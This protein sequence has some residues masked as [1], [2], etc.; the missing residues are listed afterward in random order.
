MGRN[1]SWPP[2]RATALLPF[3]RAGALLVYVTLALTGVLLHP[4]T[5]AI[6]AAAV[7]AVGGA[8]AALLRR[9]PDGL[10]PVPHPVAVAVLVAGLPGAAAAAEHL[11]PIGGVLLTAL[12]LGGTFLTWHWLLATPEPR[13]AGPASGPGTDADLHRRLLASLPDDVLLAEWRSL[14]GHG[15]TGGLRTTE[16][17]AAL[18][19]DELRTRGLR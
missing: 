17:T 4:A 11:G 14:H 18:L 8:V 6:T 10:P 13:R 7:A 1:G 9:A 15:G 12:I 3:V 19:L 5:V 16:P 2:V